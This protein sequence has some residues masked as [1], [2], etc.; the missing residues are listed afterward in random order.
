MFLR[1]GMIIHPEE[2]TDDH[3][4]VFR[5]AG[6]NVLGIHPVGG[7]NAHETLEHAVVRHAMPAWRASLE[8]AASMGIAVEYEAH[9]LRWLMPASLFE[10][11]PDWFRMSED[12]VSDPD[13]HMCASNAEALAFL[14]NRAE[15]LARLLWTGSQRWFLWPDDVTGKRCCCAGCQ[16]LSASDQALL[17][18][19]AI[20]RG[21]VRFDAEGRVCYLAYQDTLE[22]PERVQPERGVFLEFA[23]IWRDHH[24]P[25]NDSACAQNQREIRHLE[26][27]LF[28]FG[29][30]GSQVLNYWMDNSL[31]SGWR[32]PPQPFELD[33]DVMQLDVAFYRALGFENVT[34]F[35]CYLGS[36]YVRLYGKPPI[37]AYGDLLREASPEI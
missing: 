17:I 24:R 4:A 14:E 12:G 8:R 32:K 6:L 25:L 2:F 21:V 7:H 33:A 15:M 10:Q 31:F 36:D 22:V 5:Q 16:S 28:F 3:L 20:Q 30:E 1:R 18:T 23:P 34:S 29:T 9:A 11:M 27:L 19:N 26:R 35:G 13:F 37:Q